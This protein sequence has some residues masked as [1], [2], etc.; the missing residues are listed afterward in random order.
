[1]TTTLLSLFSRAPGGLSTRL[2]LAMLVVPFLSFAM[3]GDLLIL[4]FRL[5][6]THQVLSSSYVLCQRGHTVEVAGGVWTCECGLSYEGHGFQSCPGCKSVP[7]AVL[8]ACSLP[9]V[10][11]LSPWRNAR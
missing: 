1:M 9:A 2:L 5:W 11:P 3:I 8:C 6:R 7:H 10:N 4:G